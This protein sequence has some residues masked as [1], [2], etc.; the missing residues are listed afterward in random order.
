M[1]NVFDLTKREQRLVIVIVVALVAVA[2]AKHLLENRSRPAPATAPSA[3]AAPAARPT[4]SPASSPTIQA[5]EEQ[6]E[7]DNS[8]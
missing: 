6:S 2:F 4:S 8:R 1:K 3:E 5:E 7:P